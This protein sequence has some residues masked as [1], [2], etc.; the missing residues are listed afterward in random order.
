M[1]ADTSLRITKPPRGVLLSTGEHTPS[2]HSVRARLLIIEL[3]KDTIDFATGLSNCQRDAANGLY[4]AALAA[5][6]AW[7]APQY[8]KVLQDAADRL[9]ALR[10]EATRSELH[11]RTPELIANL[12]IG[13][14]LFSR[15]AVE[16]GAL[17]NSEAQKHLTEAW[18]WLGKAAQS[19]LTHQSDAD[20]AER[21][22]DIIQ[23]ALSSGQ[24]HVTDDRGTIDGLTRFEPVAG[25][26]PDNAMIATECGWV[27]THHG[28]TTSDMQQ[29]RPAGDKL[30]WVE[31]DAVFLNQTMAHHLAQH[32]AGNTEPLTVPM[33]AMAKRLLEAGALHPPDG[34][35]DRNA[36]RR[37]I[38]GKRLT[39]LRFKLERIL[40]ALAEARR[41]AALKADTTPKP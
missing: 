5:Y 9:R 16:A 8:D 40:P 6:V 36:G 10:A 1:N 21:F 29:W 7:L 30:G 17:S 31:G 26:Q 15:F 3:G 37:R 25:A 13:W 18:K 14:E 38:D 32:L 35:T 22:M 28:S 27:R 11:R 33:R 34:P 12:Y 41:L 24:C 23:S 39:V 2:G 20:Q 19:Q 4:A